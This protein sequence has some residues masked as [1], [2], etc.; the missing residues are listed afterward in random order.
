MNWFGVKLLFTALIDGDV[1]QDALVEE[2][3][4]VVQGRDVEHATER[5]AQFGRASGHNYRNE[6]GQ[7]VE[8]AF[9]RVLEVQDLCE[10]ALADGAEVFSTMRRVSP[11]DALS[12]GE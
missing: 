5:A 8:W 12:V 2:S 3:I 10:D 6:T 7:S 4:R 9:V 11:D 1:P